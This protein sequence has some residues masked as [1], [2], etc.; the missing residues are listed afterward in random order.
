VLRCLRRCRHIIII[1][2][3]TLNVRF[4]VS[5]SCAQ[6]KSLQEEKKKLEGDLNVLEKKVK[7]AVKGQRSRD[8]LIETL[9][10]KIQ[11]LEQQADEQK[12]NIAIVVNL[13]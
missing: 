7:D 3:V 5:L 12:V 11:E 1:I 9:Q 8:V 10:D 2:I 13:W 4:T 6:I